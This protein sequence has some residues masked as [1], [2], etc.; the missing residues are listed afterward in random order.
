MKSSYNYINPAD[1]ERIL[2]AIP[3]LHIR[4]W[5]VKQVEMLFKISYWCGLRINETMK[6]HVD[7][8][9]LEAK[10]VYL[11]KTKTE[12]QGIG[13]IPVLFLD[14]LA[15]FLSNSTDALFP[16]MNYAIVY[17]WTVKLGNDLG[18]KAW[19]TSQD[20]TGEKTKTHIFRKTI[21]KDM[22]YATHGTKV[23]MNI[24]SK[25]LRHTDTKTTELYL[26]ATNDDVTESGW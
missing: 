12:K 8:F 5:S 9:D 26:K 3:T 21:G 2:K 1:F 13:S 17:H 24:V 14:E 18:I 22:L 25:K 6:L 11:G 15:E 23:P 10:K 20:E 19:I 7:D 4:K 16:G